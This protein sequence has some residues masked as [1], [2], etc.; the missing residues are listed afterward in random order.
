[1]D[2]RIKKYYDML[3][4]K[5][6]FSDNEMSIRSAFQSLLDSYSE[7][8]NYTFIPELK[9]INNTRPD[10]T[11]KTNLGGDFGHWEAKDLKDDLEEEI[12][13]KANRGY[14]LKNVIFENSKDAI[15]Y[16]D[17]KIVLK[18][19]IDN[20]KELDR[21]IH[22]FFSYQTEDIKSFNNATEDFAKILPLIIND[23]R[24]LIDKASVENP[25][26]IRK[27]NEFL[28]NARKVINPEVTVEDIREILIQHILTIEIF[29][30]IFDERYF[31]SDNSIAKEV[32]EIIST[33]FKGAIRNNHLNRIQ[34]YYKIVKTHAV[35]IDDHRTKK[36]FLIS[37][38]EQFYK[39]YNPEE[40]D[41]NGIIYTPLEIVDFMIESVDILLKRHFG[42]NIESPGIRFLDPA[43]GTGTF[44]SELLSYIFN[45]QNGVYNI[46][47]IKENKLLESKY[48][49]DLFCNEISILPFYIAT[50]DIE[51]TYQ[52][53]TGEYKKF[54]NIV[55][56]DTLD[57]VLYWEKKNKKDSSLFK[58]TEENFN[59]LKLQNEKQIHVVIGNPPYNAN[60]E[61]ANQNNKNR[62]YER[63][64][65]R[66]K[67]TYKEHSTATKEKMDDPFIR[68]FRWATDRLDEEK[69]GIVAYITNDSYIFKRSFDGFRKAITDEFNYIY[70]LELG[71]D[72]YRNPKLSGTKHNVFKI[73]TGVAIIF[74]IKIP[75]SK[76]SKI[77]ISSE[78]DEYATRFEKYD[79]LKT[80]T[81]NDLKLIEF[82]LK[83]NEIDGSY[84]W[85]K[86]GRKKSDFTKL[87]CLYS[88][89]RT[90]LFLDRYPGI[91]TA[92]DG[93]VFDL[94]KLNLEKKIDYMT[95]IYNNSIGKYTPNKVTENV[96][97]IKW[98]ANLEAL[99]KKKMRLPK[100]EKNKV[101]KFLYRPF[102]ETNYY[103][104]KL[105]SD[106]LTVN[107]FKIFGISLDNDNL[108]ICHSGASSTREFQ[109]IIT[110]KLFSFDLVEKTQAIPLYLYDE[111]GN[112]IISINKDVHTELE[113]KLGIKIK[114]E[115]LF[116]YT[117]AVLNSPKFVKKY[118]DELLKG[119]PRIIVSENF[120]K[121]A[122][123]GNELADIHLHFKKQKEFNLEVEIVNKFQ[124]P[125]VILDF[126]TKK[127]LVRLDENTFLTGFPK[128][129]NEYKLGLRSPVEWILD[130]YSPP[131]KAKYEHEKILLKEFNSYGYHKYKDEIISLIK[132]MTTLT[133]E[134]LRIRREI[135]DLL[136]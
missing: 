70:I 48:D 36:K 17:E 122:S 93:W 100:Y 65:K 77:L 4:S 27:R 19:H 80:Y 96:K 5:K 87:L 24:N 88:N 7:E 47:Y 73:K 57:N 44:I 125:K 14:S 133:V 18:A 94:D 120:G 95:K 8:Y 82:D 54:E 42:L 79:F 71:G 106:R 102:F 21:V 50:L 111:Y 69:G 78:I 52:K 136:F 119:Y 23:L 129:I 16:Q 108:I 46:D 131:K 3:K 9:A 49:S 109:V 107:H 39:I 135:D 105:F 114:A 38:Y 110:N 20:P 99:F 126:D 29:N 104:D 28:D 98:S 63:I 60:Q 64:D 83:K 132:K 32:E 53:L 134:T 89:D 59:R 30:S 90:S 13:K 85:V 72:I 112:K 76:E 51:H 124:Q 22:S 68:F 62:K 6:K 66:V 43:T 103:S 123:L 31:A 113:K 12:R 127:N 37:M 118:A 15:L 56:A 40:A 58:I 74:L 92:R 91:N 117:Y 45:K 130:R 116:F 61:N 35:K 11:I 2:Y 1:M 41:K 84:E 128:E 86:K 115:S 101:K 25:D 121:I 26:Y 67:E 33:F 10:G 97:H 34:N 75:K 81:L 55:Y